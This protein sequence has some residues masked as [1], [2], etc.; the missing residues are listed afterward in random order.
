MND[1]NNFAY[2]IPVSLQK[3]HTVCLYVNFIDKCIKV[4]YLIYVGTI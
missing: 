3:K 2:L 4:E 1:K